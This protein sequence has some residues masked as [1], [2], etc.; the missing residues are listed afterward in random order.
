MN[1]TRTPAQRR[2]MTI[3]GIGAI[4]GLGLAGCSSGDTS[5]DSATTAS[6]A[7]TT[8]EAT[9][10]GGMESGEAMAA[11]PVGPGCA[12]YVQQVPSGPGS[13]EALAEGNVVDAVSTVPILTTLASAVSGGLNPEVNLVSTLEGGPFT[14]FAPVDTAFAALDPA[15]V[16]SLGTDAPALTNVLTYHVVAGEAAP[17]AVAG[18][19]ATVQGSDLTVTGE[20]DALTVNGANVICGGI[21][22][23]NAT[24]YLIDAVL[25]PPQ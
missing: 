21:E 7:D 17:D 4:A 15:V 23:T 8:T 24:V 5:S 16:D 9:T 10:S 20:P 18:S 19:H 2:I 12:D 11:G 13:I 1:S 14:V 6:S 3:I 25:T 22:T